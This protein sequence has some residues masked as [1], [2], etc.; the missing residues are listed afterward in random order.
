MIREAIEKIADLVRGANAIQVVDSQKLRTVFVKDKDEPMD[1]HEY[2]AMPRAGTIESLT[3]FCLVAKD[4]E[5]A[6]RPEVWHSSQGLTLL[7][8]R[9]DRHERL[10][11]PLQMSERFS[12]LWKL[13]SGASYSTSGIVS[14]LRY[15]LH[16][17]GLDSLVARL[18]K[19]NFERKGTGERTVE[20]G[21]E[22]FGKSVEAQI[23]GRDDIPDEFA[24]EVPV[25]VTGGL[26]SATTARVRVGLEIDVEK[27]QFRVRTLA[28][29]IEE[30]LI[31]AQ[32]AIGDALR[33][34][35]DCPV[36]H[37]VPGSTT[38]T[39]TSA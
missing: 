26:R 10:V 13:A 22:S 16:S 38:L 18:R 28:D 35:L 36:Y 14:L 30:T 32:L 23:Q 21:R 34:T 37:G 27:E 7:C 3:D 4:A 39:I 15:E 6:P 5:V 1:A 24:V 2:P 29:E 25:Y 19:V 8:D 9:D 12:L 17:A 31:T 33:N 11:M 20:H